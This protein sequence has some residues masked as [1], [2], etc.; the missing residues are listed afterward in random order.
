MFGAHDKGQDN[1]YIVT[2]KKFHKCF[3]DHGFVFKF[4]HIQFNHFLVMTNA[5]ISFESIQNSLYL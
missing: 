3:S 1:V 5:L 4:N 2:T